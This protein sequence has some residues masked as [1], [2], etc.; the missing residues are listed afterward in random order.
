VDPVE[1]DRPAR[2]TVADRD[3]A[4][5]VSFLSVS[6]VVGISICIGAVGG[7]SGK[8]R[9]YC[10]IPR[11]VPG[12]CSVSGLEGCVVGRLGGGSGET[13]REGIVSLRERNAGG[14]VADLTVPSLKSCSRGCS[15]AEPSCKFSGR[16]DAKVDVALRVVCPYDGRDCRVSNVD[17]VS[18]KKPLLLRDA[19][20]FSSG[21]EDIAISESDV[22]KSHA[23]TSPSFAWSSSL[24]SPLTALP[25][26]SEIIMDCRTPPDSCHRAYRVIRSLKVDVGILDVPLIYRVFDSS[27]AVGRYISSLNRKDT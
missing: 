14:A 26:R 25:P 13:G 8:R 1:S 27:S 6:S 16:V 9:S 19:R 12:R 2:V 7:I 15:A 21:E 5:G 17:D 23:I 18:S 24:S 20:V 10:V 3:R 4:P 22:S 11:A